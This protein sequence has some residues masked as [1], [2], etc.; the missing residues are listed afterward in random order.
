MTATLQE[1]GLYP[2]QTIAL[3]AS[4]QGVLKSDIA[5]RSSV[6]AVLI[7]LA[8]GVVFIGLSLAGK[9]HPLVGAAIMLSSSIPMS[10]ACSITRNVDLDS[11]YKDTKK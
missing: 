10:I 8:L 9:A 1:I 6:C 5:H 4:K 7:L 3:K 11:I 2:P